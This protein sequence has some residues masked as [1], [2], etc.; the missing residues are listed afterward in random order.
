MT[1]FQAPHTLRTARGTMLE[2]KQT[3]GGRN[4]F[5]LGSLST[6]SRREMYEI[7]RE[8]LTPT[9]YVGDRPLERPGDR[10]PSRGTF[11][12]LRFRYRLKLS[13]VNMLSARRCGRKSVSYGPIHPSRGRACRCWCRHKRGFK[14]K[15]KKTAKRLKTCKRENCLPLL[16]LP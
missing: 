11:V 16:L 9:V 8:L 3:R 14:K 7:A 15:K 10:S 13:V 1:A 12:K 4:I 2:A 6:L 5:T